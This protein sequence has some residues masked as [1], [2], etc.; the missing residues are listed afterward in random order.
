MGGKFWLDAE[1]QVDVSKVHEKVD[2]L[3]E[4]EKTESG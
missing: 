1:L 2:K 3:E 4:K